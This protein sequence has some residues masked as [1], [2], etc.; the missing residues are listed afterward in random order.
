M[1]DKAVVL[2]GGVIY[3]G[4][5][6]RAALDAIMDIR[7]VHR[8]PASWPPWSTG[9]GRGLPIQPDS[10]GLDVQVGEE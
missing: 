1:Q 5:T 9:A 6:T 7:A 4:R 10:V 8:L 3:T 2:I